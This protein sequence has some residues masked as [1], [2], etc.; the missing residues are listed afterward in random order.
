MQIEYKDE[1]RS[2]YEYDQLCAMDGYEG[3]PE[4]D[5]ADRDKYD[6]NMPG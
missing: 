1:V 5:A 4:R 2:Q 6:L 3:A